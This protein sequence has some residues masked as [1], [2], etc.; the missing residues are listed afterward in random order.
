[1]PVVVAC[2]KWVVDEAY[3]R[4][5][6]DCKLDFSSVD[7]KIGEYDRNA[8][9]EAVRLRD[10]GGG[11]SVIGVTVGAPESAKGVKDGL[12]RGMDQAFFV[13]DP[14]FKDLEPSQTAAILAEVIRT[15]IPHYDLITC[16]EGSSDL[17]AQQV[18]PRLAELLCIPCVCFVQKLALE[19][20]KLVADRRVEDGVEVVEAPL[21]ALVTVLPDINTPRIPGVKDTLMA[22][23]KPITTIKREE[24]AGGFEGVL[25]TASMTAASLERTGEKLAADAAGITR[26]VDVLR[27]S[28]VI[29]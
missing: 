24:L 1:M 17:Y 10:A 18:G 6:S 14:S 9:E 26:F 20:G 23:K 16:G 4:K 11:G 13:S 27:K 25:K 15:R 7:Y 5:G 12:S 21:P 2:F 28:G 29:R 19:G 22:G 8:I 3:I